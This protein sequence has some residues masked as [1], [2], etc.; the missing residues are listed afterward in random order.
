MTAAESATFPHIT[1]DPEVVGGEPVVKGT[2][3]PVRSI[4]ILARFYHDIDELCA[5]FPRVSRE[6]IHEA[7]AYYGH[8]WEEIERYIAENED[9]E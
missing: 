8:H 9:D 6:A 3:V 7:M 4:A 1:R 5:A 2:R